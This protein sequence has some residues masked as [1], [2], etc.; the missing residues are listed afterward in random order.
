MVSFCVGLVLVTFSGTATFFG[1]RFP[2]NVATYKSGN[3]FWQ[4]FLA[5]FSGVATFLV[6][7]RRS[8]LETRNITVHD[9]FI[10]TD[11]Y[12]RI[13]IVIVIFILQQH[14]NIYKQN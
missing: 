14:D 9:R 6:V 13:A 2:K 7:A 4:G 5:K 1:V 10:G 12:G 8:I 3:T 11:F